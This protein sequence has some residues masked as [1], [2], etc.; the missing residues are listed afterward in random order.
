MF[1][2]YDGKHFFAV[3]LYFVNYIFIDIIY[4]LSSSII[5]LFSYVPHG[6]DDLQ[7]L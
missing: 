2:Y 1:K 6:T 3:D 5:D 4:N 7:M